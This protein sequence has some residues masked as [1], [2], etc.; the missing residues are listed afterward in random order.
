MSINFRGAK[1]SFKYLSF[2]DILEGN[3]SQ[4]D[5]QGK[6]ALFGTS[7]ITLADLRA[8]VYE[9]DNTGYRTLS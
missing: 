3:Y 8:M 4:E 2:V 7:A 6:F 5:V 1:N 9:S